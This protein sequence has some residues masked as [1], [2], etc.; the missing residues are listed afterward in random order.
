M[1]WIVYYCSIK[2]ITNQL[3]KHLSPS[4]LG[5]TEQFFSR[6]HVLAQKV[7]TLQH[8]AEIINR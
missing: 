6:F 4:Y 5:R 7:T 2:A 3:T 8:I 1:T